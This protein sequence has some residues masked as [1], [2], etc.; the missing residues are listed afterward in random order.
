MTSTFDV[1][2]ALT[3]CSCNIPNHRLTCILLFPVNSCRTFLQF[4]PTCNTP[5]P[6]MLSPCVT[7]TC[8]RLGSHSSSSSD[9]TYQSLSKT[10]GWTNQGCAQISPCKNVGVFQLKQSMICQNE[11]VIITFYI[12]MLRKIYCS[13]RRLCLT[14]IHVIVYR[15][16]HL[17]LW[18]S[19][20]RPTL[21]FSE[22]GWQ[23]YKLT[24]K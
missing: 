5:S 15:N 20:L 11:I 18:C 16:T 1:Y 4:D 17:Y 21:S 8:A 13:I 2:K 3:S 7:P 24:F 12:L 23:M 9:Q 22:Q 10:A 19:L 6:S 14:K